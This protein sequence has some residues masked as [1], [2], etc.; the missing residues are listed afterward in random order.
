MDFCSH[1]LRFVRTSLASLALSVSVVTAAPLCGQDSPT[2]TSTFANPHFSNAAK[3]WGLTEPAK[4]AVWGDLDGD[5]WLDVITDAR[6]VWLNRPKTG[7]GRHFVDATNES[8]LDH[9]FTKLG[10]ARPSNFVVL[11]DVDGD[12]DL[13]IFSGVTLEL[14][15]TKPDPDD[16]SKTVPFRPDPK[17]RSAILLNDGHARFERVEASGVEEPAHS[18]TCATF[19]DYDRDG[20]LDLFVGN[21]YCRYGSSYDAY[22][23]RLY[24]GSGDGTFADV[25]ETAGL[26]TVTKAGTPAS[27][28]P[29]YG[30]TAGDLDGD[31]DDDLFVSSYG[32]RWNMLW[33]NEGDGTFREIGAETRFDGDAE[34]S[35]E[36]PNGARAGE[37]PFRANGNSFDC[38][39][40]DF[41][42]D[43]DLDAFMADITHA[44]AGPSSDRSTLLINGG[45][46]DSFAFTRATRGIDRS[47]AGERWNQGDLYCGWIDA[48]GDGWQDLM[49]ASGDY[50]DNQRLRIFTQDS[51]HQFQDATA[52]LG[53]DWEGCGAPTVGDVDRDGDPDILIGRSLNRLDKATRA[54]LGGQPALWLNPSGNDTHWITIRLRGRGAGGCNTEGIGSKIR[55]R[56]GSGESGVV[57]RYRT[58]TSSGGHS[59]HQDEAVIF[60]GVGSTTKVDELSIT[61]AN[62]AKSVSV[63]R[64]LPVDHDYTLYEPLSEDDRRVDMQP[65]RKR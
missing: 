11:G 24:R 22:P 38:R 25:T 50:P 61:W 48:N 34:R 6:R 23:D 35:G 10:K 19:F 43:G 65:H 63:Y 9:R 40:A 53:L 54:K 51:S 32:R 28:K 31:G 29:T 59:G 1:T 17:V 56:L 3:S 21:W 4:R 26:L 45:A 52:A 60:L 20:I 47:H 49:L 62:G 14:E 15:R 42:E 2:S 33:Q 18:S 44:W 7:G 37:K 39:L 16:P 30:V 27:S 64:N 5:G 13:D 36:Y 57:T 46:E 41:D 58:M 55:A 8:K 12:G